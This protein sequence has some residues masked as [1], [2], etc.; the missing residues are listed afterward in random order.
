MNTI[1]AKLQEMRENARKERI[2]R[3]AI[4]EA[5]H[6]VMMLLLMREASYHIVLTP[7]TGMG[8]TVP[9]HF[10]EAVLERAPIL[11][12]GYA[13]EKLYDS[14]EGETSLGDYMFHEDYD[15]QDFLN[16][17][18]D[19]NAEGKL[20]ERA[21]IFELKTFECAVDI[22]KEYK[23]LIYLLAGELADAEET[24]M[25]YN[26]IK[27]FCKEYRDA[28]PILGTIAFPFPTSKDKEFFKEAI[29]EYRMEQENAIS[30][31]NE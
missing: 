27:K 7:E 19:L 18:R 4:H 22:L 11:M 3:I 12:A 28:Y 8:M 13:A 5:G 10:P 14:P 21:Y 29:D 23:A 2:N 30:L 20:T 17:C 24:K 6:F 1:E 16:M 31:V 15:N 9:F 26:A 25:D